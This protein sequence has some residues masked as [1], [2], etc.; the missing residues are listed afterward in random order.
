M[1]GQE[2]WPLIGSAEWIRQEYQRQLVG[3]LQRLIRKRVKKQEEEQR[4]L[5]NEVVDAELDGGLPVPKPCR[6]SKKEQSTW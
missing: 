1:E 3:Q 2:R 5:V 6:N 4:Q